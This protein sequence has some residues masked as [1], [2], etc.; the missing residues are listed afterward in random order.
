[1]NL[2]HDLCSRLSKFFMSLRVFGGISSLVHTVPNHEV[3]LK[4]GNASLCV[5]EPYMISPWVTKLI[6]LPRYCTK[7]LC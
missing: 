6:L 4:G 3:D 5:S 2:Y 7:I 1:M